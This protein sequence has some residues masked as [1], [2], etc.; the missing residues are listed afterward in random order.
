MKNLLVALLFVAIAGVAPA[1]TLHLAGDSTLAWRAETDPSG[2]WGEALRPAL[3]DGVR[4]VNYAIS[5][6]STV[7]F[8][9]QWEKK[10]LPQVQPGDFVIIQFGHNDPWHTTKDRIAK[11]ETDRYCPVADYRANLTRYVR[12]AQAKGARVLVMTPTPQRAFFKGQEWMPSARHQPYFAAIPEVAAETGAEFLDMTAFGGEKVKAMGVEGSRSVYRVNVNNKGDDVHPNKVGAR[13][14]AGLFLEEV[15][16]R[17]LAIGHLFNHEGV[18]AKT[19]PT[20]P[21]ATT[22]GVAK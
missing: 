17:K 19:E 15:R 4:L 14:L 3:R 1:T 11:G 8:R 6:T 7:T 20:K 16:N 13:M 10:L 22:A 5:G 2:S 21:G 18:S 12:E 9:P